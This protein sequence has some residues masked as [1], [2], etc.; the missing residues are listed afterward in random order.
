MANLKD[1]IV[2]GNL[3]VTGKVVASDILAN[4]TGNEFDSIKVNNI[5][6]NTAD[7]IEI[8]DSVIT[9]CSLSAPGGVYVNYIENLDGDLEMTSGN[10]LNF[11]AAE[12]CS[13][14]ANSIG[15]T[16]AN[17][18]C[19]QSATGNQLLLR[20]NELIPGT[21]KTM[22]SGTSNCRWNYGYFDTVDA[23]T[24][25]YTPSVQNSGGISLSCGGSITLSATSAGG[26]YID[27]NAK[28]SIRPNVSIVP[29]VTTADLGSST[30]T[31][32]SAYINKIC[33]KNGV[34]IG[35]HGIGNIL[36]SSTGMQIYIPSTDDVTWKSG[37]G[38]SYTHYGPSGSYT[39]VVKALSNWS[40]GM[41]GNSTLTSTTVTFSFAGKSLT[42]SMSLLYN[43]SA[44][45][46]YYSGSTVSKST[47][48]TLEYGKTYTLTVSCTATQITRTLKKSAVYVC[49]TSVTQGEGTIALCPTG[50]IY[51][52]QTQI[53]GQS[54]AGTDIVIGAGGKTYCSMSS[55]TTSWTF[56]SDKRD[57]ADIEQL[58]ASLSFIK[59]LQPITYVDNMREYYYN[60]DGSFNQE[61][62]E[63]QILK[64][65]RRHAGFLAQD[66]YDLI[67]KEYN[68]DNY[69]SVVSYNKYN[70]ISDEEMDR[71]S[72]NSSQLIPFLVKA[73]QEQQEIIDKLQARIETLEQGDK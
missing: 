61:S 45:M 27:L 9:N 54:S 8:Q 60:D 35:G 62:Y 5:Y 34:I 52:G 59:Q 43:Y 37:S 25:V 12:Y 38:I 67:K 68:T 65:H 28:Y 40:V 42:Q 32:Q 72:F 24:K 46:Y 36:T 66:V 16:S 14:N 23:L 17:D 56:T 4:G 51:S 21:T 63:R 2:L 3:T 7:A 57:K 71:Y 53:G 31:W 49:P 58:K 73:I 70:H 22:T 29:S 13:I 11:S 69:A 6:V 39:W 33:M 55:P 41:A 15:L 1:T 18:V 64:K 30:Y 19:F 20:G 10:A 47:T 48:V 50:Y 26:G 44:D